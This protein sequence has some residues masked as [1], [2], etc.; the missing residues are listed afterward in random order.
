MLRNEHCQ[1]QALGCLLNV[2]G[3][4]LNGGLVEA[5][6][7]FGVEVQAC[8]CGVIRERERNG[9]DRMNTVRQG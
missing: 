1:L 4:A 2:I 3:G 6:G 8:P 5:A 9:E 7:A